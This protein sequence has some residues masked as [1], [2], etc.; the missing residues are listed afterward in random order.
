MQATQANQSTDQLTIVNRRRG[1]LPAG[2]ALHLVNSYVS[3][4]DS[5][6]KADALVSYAVTD[7]TPTG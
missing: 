1:W 2:F 5:G 4:A 6:R 3:N 7:L